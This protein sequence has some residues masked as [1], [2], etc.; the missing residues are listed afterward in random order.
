MAA[1]EGY[2]VLNVDGSSIGNLGPAGFGGIFRDNDG[3]WMHGFV[4]SIGHANNLLTELLALYNGLSLAWRK[5]YWGLIA[6][7]I[8]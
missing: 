4:G 2:I 7:L 3:S 1:Y 5:G 6:T 8:P